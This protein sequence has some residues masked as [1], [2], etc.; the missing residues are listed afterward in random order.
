MFIPTA[1][2]RTIHDVRNGYSRS[3]AIWTG[4]IARVLSEKV[5]TFA[6]LIHMNIVDGTKGAAPL[7]LP[8]PT[9]TTPQIRTGNFGQL[10]LSD[11]RAIAL[12]SIRSL[13]MQSL[14]RPY[15]LRC[16]IDTRGP[17]SPN[18]ACRHRYSS[19]EH[20]LETSYSFEVVETNLVVCNEELLDDRVCLVFR[21]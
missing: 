20:Q 4:A 2:T 3:Q 10:S 9:F 18:R 19:H 6:K 7:K 12:H 13:D 15:I 8:S 17:R 16:C 21:F 14:A 5:S 11:C 1:R